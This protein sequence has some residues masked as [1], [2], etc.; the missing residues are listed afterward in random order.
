LQ[1]RQQWRKQESYKSCSLWHATCCL[2]RLVLNGLYFVSPVVAEACIADRSLYADDTNQLLWAGVV[3]LLLPLNVKLV[4]ISDRYIDSS[5]PVKWY[6]VSSYH[7]CAAAMGCFA[8]SLYSAPQL[9]KKCLKAYSATTGVPV[10]P[11]TAMSTAIKLV[12]L[13]LLYPVPV[14]AHCNELA[15]YMIEGIWPTMN[16]AAKKLS[17]VSTS[18]CMR[19]CASE[20]AILVWTV[21]WAYASNQARLQMGMLFNETYE[22][23]AK[24]WLT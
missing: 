24:W 23:I 17:R 15:E 1:R 2:I 6:P 18:S 16:T 7:L 10:S 4:V 3:L 5:T 21:L 20:A 22:E 11:F 8:L 13:S 19:R 12:K 14:I 9:Y